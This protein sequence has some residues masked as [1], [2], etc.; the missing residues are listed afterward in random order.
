MDRATV[1]GLLAGIAVILGSIA[2]AG[3]PLPAFVHGPALLC[4]VGG[5]LAAV[6][7][8]TP[9]GSL[10]ALPEAIWHVLFH[11][12]ED[13]DALLGQMLA[14][15]EIARRQGLLAMEARIKDSHHPLLILGLQMV[16]D[17]TAPEVIEQVLC[18]EM[19]MAAARRRE[20]RHVLEQLGRFGP[21]FGMIG[22]LLGL[23]IML[24]DLTDPLAIGPGLAVALLTT[25]YGAVLANL[26]W[27]PMAEKIASQQ[28]HELR[29]MELILQGVLYLQSGDHP[30]MMERK[31][32]TFART[33]S[34]PQER[35]A[36]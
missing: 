27:L 16:V 30:R 19:E 13:P 24:R 23:V 28:R 34:R 22:T 15:A 4:V 26:L 21:S 7:I 6:L 8:C 1:L 2:A 18:T 33:R 35:R 5:S 14:Y 12:S 36:A 31:L 29:T 32:R 3:A 10:R 25:L 11:K 17:G 20:A 9:P